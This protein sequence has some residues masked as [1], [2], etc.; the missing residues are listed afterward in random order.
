MERF[1]MPRT[2]NVPSAQWLNLEKQKS[3]LRPVARSKKKK[4]RLSPAWNLKKNRSQARPRIAKKKK[5][6]PGQLPDFKQEVAAQPD[7]SSQ[8]GYVASQH[9]LCAEPADYKTVVWSRSCRLV[10]SKRFNNVLL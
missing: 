10:P 5:S 6:Q 3:L 9:Q 7:P 8:K 2:S 4:P 1:E